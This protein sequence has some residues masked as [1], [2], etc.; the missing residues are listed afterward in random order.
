MERIGIV[1]LSSILMEKK[2]KRNNIEVTDSEK[3]KDETIVDLTT[4]LNK[5]TVVFLRML[6]LLLPSALSRRQS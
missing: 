4:G 1:R 3:R 2:E 5:L 6:T